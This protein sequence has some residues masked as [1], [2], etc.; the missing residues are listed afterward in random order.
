[1]TYS[2][3]NGAGDSDACTRVCA[4]CGRVEVENVWVDITPKAILEMGGQV[5]HGIC[6]GCVDG[7][8]RYD[9]EM[10]RGVPLA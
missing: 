7:M 4:W 10:S 5:S 3:P 8:T 1:M 2:T 6:Q 9:D